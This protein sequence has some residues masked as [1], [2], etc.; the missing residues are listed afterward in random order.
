[1][2]RWRGFLRLTRCCLCFFFFTLSLLRFNRP[3]HDI[4]VSTVSPHNSILPESYRRVQIFARCAHFTPRRGLFRLHALAAR[5]LA[6]R[7]GSMRFRAWFRRLRG[8]NL[9]SSLILPPLSLLV[10]YRLIA[11]RSPSDAPI[12]EHFECYPRLEDYANVATLKQPPF[13][14]PWAPSIESRKPEKARA[15]LGRRSVYTFSRVFRHSNVSRGWQSAWSPT[16]NTRLRHAHGG[17]CKF[18]LYASLSEIYSA[19]RKTAGSSHFP[20]NAVI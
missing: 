18:S 5:A 13:S 19:S 2:P 20:S 1:M 6:G 12:A 9:L 16:R 10:R 7:R 8:R 11:Y 17:A 14:L 4:D 3:R 15:A